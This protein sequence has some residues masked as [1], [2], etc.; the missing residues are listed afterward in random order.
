MTSTPTI[1]AS[2]FG[3]TKFVSN[4]P[5]LQMCLVPKWSSRSSKAAWCE[6]ILLEGPYQKPA[7]NNCE[8]CNKGFG[9]KNGGPNLCWGMLLFFSFSSFGGVF[10]WCFGGS[11]TVLGPKTTGETRVTNPWEYCILVATGSKIAK[12]LKVDKDLVEKKNGSPTPQKK[13]TSRNVG[14]HQPLQKWWS[15]KLIVNDDLQRCHEFPSEF[16]YLQIPHLK[17]THSTEAPGHLAIPCRRP[18][19]FGALLRSWAFT[20]TC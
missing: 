7:R 4:W 6:R 14:S 2:F 9:G 20:Y 10:S 1:F 5:T 17:K 16:L 13:C 15:P 11:K 3:G 18:Y 12:K 8:T 19:T